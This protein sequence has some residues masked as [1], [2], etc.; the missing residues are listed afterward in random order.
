[1]FATRVVTTGGAIAGTIGAVDRAQNPEIARS[2]PGPASARSVLAP[3]TASAP[4]AAR[5]A[6]RGER[7]IFG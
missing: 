3:V 2:D 4:E 6:K 5:T 7:K 1:M